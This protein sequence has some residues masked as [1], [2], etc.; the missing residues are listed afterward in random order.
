MTE[1]IPE[2]G[3]TK[4]ALVLNEDGQPEAVYIRDDKRAALV[5]S[6]DPDERWFLI[7]PYRTGEDYG[8]E[9][10]LTWR[11]ITR[12]AGCTVVELTRAPALV[13]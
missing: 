4:L 9:F 11:N 5:G 2:P 3:D 6:P 7:D 10:P 13:G 8:I 12:N 1:R